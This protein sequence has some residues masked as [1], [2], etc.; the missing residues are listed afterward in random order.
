MTAETHL[1]LIVDRQLPEFVRED[2]PT[3]VAFVE[4]Y[5]EY[6]VS[7][8][9]DISDVKDIDKTM[10]DFIVYFQNELAVNLPIVVQDERM[11]LQHIKD[12]YLAKGSE[13]S[14]KLLFRL[15]FGKNVE[16]T[17]PGEQMLIPSDGRWNQEISVFVDV[18][19]GDPE[20]VVGKLV[21]ISSGDRVLSVLIDRKEEL[22]GEVDRV[23]LVGNNVYEMYLDK[24]F[25][26]EIS[27]GDKIRYLDEFQATILPATTNISITQKGKNF[28][29]GQVFELKQG[30]GT[31]ALLKITETNSTGGIQRAELIKFGIGYVADFALSILATNS[32]TAKQ[33]AVSATATRI[34]VDTDYALGAGA[35]TWLGTD[36]SDGSTTVTGVSGTDFGGTGAPQVGDELYVARDS[37]TDEVFVGVI[38]SIESSSSLTLADIPSF[39]GTS[40]LYEYHNPNNDG[41]QQTYIDGNG[42]EQ[43]SQ[44]NKTTLGDSTQ[45]FEE[46]GYLNRGDVL[47]G[48]GGGGECYGATITNAG[49]GYTYATATVAASPDSDGVDATVASVVINSD[50][51]IEDITFDERGSGY[52]IGSTPTIT[53]SGDGSGATATA[54]IS[55][56]GGYC[57]ST[58]AGTI[59]REFALNSANA[60]AES[61]DPAVIEV[62][63]GALN[64]YPG[65]FETNSG[66]LSDSIFIQD[67]FYYQKFS[68]VLRI[69]E[70]LNRYKSAVRTM[71]HPAG[72]KLFGEFDI[73]N[74]YDIAPALESLVKSL[75]IGLE[76]D[77]RDINDE[78]FYWTLTKDFNDSATVSHTSSDIRKR[79]DKV[80]ADSITTP[81]DVW[82]HFTTKALETS[83]VGTLDDSDWVH[84]TTKSL[85]TSISAPNDSAIVKLSDKGFSDSIS[86][87]EELDW[88]MTKY[89]ED[90]SVGSIVNRADI[91]VNSYNAQDYWIY[92][93]EYEG[94]LAE[95]TTN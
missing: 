84:N 70:R 95:T 40:E 92:T 41:A 86:S 58:F 23:K 94:G 90:N 74:E 9:V 21:E 1:N 80:F 38:A 15:L 73:S 4:A 47:V 10:D 81:T 57:D 44:W 63:L 61:D 85:E 28:R 30:S 64:R 5:Y 3:F 13:G 22:I 78:E 42:Q 27:S 93:E 37:S 33:T 8:G 51:E 67:S 20:E 82:T 87:S 24:R 36:D 72:M 68:Y 83:S 88:N 39:S 55:E 69:D 18:D 62:T 12:H 29:V 50:G 65:Y 14:F 56:D 35:I 75:G 79:S 6:M 2:Y 91:Y 11:L 19:Y 32:V 25:F 31:G 49:S 59:L 89:I 17:Y 71:V 77:Y 46:Q 76:D 66:F 54:K 16:L 26:G 7:Q 43:D 52:T 53:I 60:Q 34:T 48:F 45:G